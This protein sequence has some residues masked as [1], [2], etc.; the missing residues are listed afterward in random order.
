MRSGSLFT[1]ERTCRFSVFQTQPRHWILSA[2]FENCLSS[3]IRT[4]RDLPALK[5]YGNSRGSFLHITHLFN[6]SAVPH[7]ATTSLATAS[8]FR[9]SSRSPSPICRAV[10]PVPT[11][12]SRPVILTSPKLQ[13]CPQRIRRRG[14]HHRLCHPRPRSRP[15]QRLPPTPPPPYSPSRRPPRAAA[16][17]RARAEAMTACRPSGPDSACFSRHAPYHVPHHVPDRIPG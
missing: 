7:A 1:M 2:H 4:L 9:K 12:G 13:I 8:Q 5:C 16:V 15:R 17:P 11:Q 6:H 3:I 14:R 10:Q